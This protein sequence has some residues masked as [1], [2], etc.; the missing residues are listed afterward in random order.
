M[1]LYMLTMR[2]ARSAAGATSFARQNPPSMVK[3]RRTARTVPVPRIGS[4]RC[5]I[6][7]LNQRYSTL[8]LILC[9]QNPA[10]KWL[11]P[12]SGSRVG[13][14]DI[15]H[16]LVRVKKSRRHANSIAGGTGWRPPPDKLFQVALPSPEGKLRPSGTAAELRWLE[17][18]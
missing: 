18:R 14:D 1:K 11:L 7:D 4:K 3:D 6:I 2:G 15:I 16:F 8:Y 5:V 17:T 10:V 13:R 9:H 12:G